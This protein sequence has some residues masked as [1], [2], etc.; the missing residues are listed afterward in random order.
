MPIMTPVGSIGVP[1]LILLFAIL[2]F[3][4]GSKKLVGM[5]RDIGE[6]IR[7]FKESFEGGSTPKSRSREE[8]E[9]EV[10][11]LRKRIAELEEK[12]KEKRG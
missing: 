11:E 8:L 7:A 3:I 1:E 5:A 9:K 10:T 12:L 6:A 2:V 4:F